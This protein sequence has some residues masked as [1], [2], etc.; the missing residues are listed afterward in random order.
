[1]T[2]SWQAR[3]VSFLVRYRIKPRLADLSDVGRVRRVFAQPLPAP[4]GVRYTDAVVGG[5]AGE[6]VD[7][8]GVA[9]ANTT[10]LYLHGGGFVGCSPRTHRP[11]TAALALRD[12]LQT[13]PRR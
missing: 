6:W 13:A 9:A 11:I 2:P 7:A 1:M 12:F 4:K 8:D 10:L 3:I 5:V